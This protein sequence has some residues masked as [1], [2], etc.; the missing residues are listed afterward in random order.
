[1]ISG[2][3]GSGACSALFGATQTDGVAPTNTLDAMLGLVNA[4]GTNVGTLYALSRSSDA[5]TPVLAAAP[6]D[7][8]LPLAFT[9]GGLDGPSTVAIDASGKVWVVNYF[10]VASLFSNTGAPAF[11]NGITGY[12]LQESYGGAVDGNNVMWIAN[13]ESDGSI[14]GGLGSVTLLNTAGPALPGDSLYAAGGLNFATAVAIDSTNTAWMTDYGDGSLTLLSNAGVPQSG[15]SGYTSQQFAFPVAVAVDSKRN[16]WL[17]NQ[18]AETVTEITPY[19][20]SITSYTVGSGPSGIAVDAADNVWSANYYGNSVGLVS[21][22]KVLSSGGF[23]GGGLDHPVGIAADGNGTVWVTNYRAPGLTELE[24]VSGALPGTAI[25]PVA[26]WAPDI[27]PLEAYGIAIDAAGNVW[28]TS[29][30]DN[31]LI[32]YVGLAAPVKTPLLGA[33]RIP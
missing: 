10:G 3:A 13:E 6:A 5:F 22:G 30:G 32:E 31:R 25:S 9:G 26:G 24:C 2:A 33:T 19:G 28:I 12:G 20:S 21:G 8:T 11:A 7:W 1:M 17:A 27:A 16:G 23:V 14:N 18:S 4:P 15:P 29:F